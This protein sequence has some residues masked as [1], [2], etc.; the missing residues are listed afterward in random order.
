MSAIAVGNVAPDPLLGMPVGSELKIESCLF[1]S[2]IE[3]DSW[4]YYRGAMLQ[5]HWRSKD[6]EAIDGSAAIVAPGVAIAARHVIDHDDRLQRVLKGDLILSLSGVIVFGLDLWS[7]RHVTVKDGSDLCIL[8]L[9]RACDLPADNTLRQVSLTRK[10]PQVGAQVMLAGFRVPEPVALGSGNPVRI[11]GGMHVS[12]GLVTAVYPEK[13]D[14][15]MLPWPCIELNVGASGGVSGGPAFDQDGRMIGILC[16][17]LGDG[18]DGT[19]YVSLVDP[20]L[21]TSFLHAWPPGLHPAPISLLG[22][23]SRVCSIDGRN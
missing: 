9:K 1:P 12:V 20:I 4:A 10:I 17:A 16:S 5:L 22:M 14:T 18:A 11:E 23:D 7:V 6:T 2:T 19:S 21:S 15:V 13:R 8:S 3:P